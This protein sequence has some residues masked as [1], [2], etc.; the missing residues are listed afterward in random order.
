MKMIYTICVGEDFDCR[1][2]LKCKSNKAKY[3]IK[4]TNGPMKEEDKV[5][6]LQVIM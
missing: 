1:A 2:A 3:E 6:L 4:S 5:E